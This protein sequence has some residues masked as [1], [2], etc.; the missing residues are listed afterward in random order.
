MPAVGLSEP[1]KASVEKA[2]RLT[3]TGRTQERRMRFDLHVVPD[4]AM[5]VPRKRKT[6]SKPPLA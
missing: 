3:P 2:I 5:K 1:A 4:D 6:G